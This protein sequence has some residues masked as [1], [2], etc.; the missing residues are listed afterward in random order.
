VSGDDWT[1]QER[2]IE[3][4]MRRVVHSFGPAYKEELSIPSIDARFASRDHWLVGAA[5]CLKAA[6]RVRDRIGLPFGVDLAILL[7]SSAE[8]G[9]GFATMSELDKELSDVAPML[10]LSAYPHPEP[11][12]GGIMP[13]TPAAPL[14]V[15]SPP[16]RQAIRERFDDSAGRYIRVLWAQG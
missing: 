9:W 15:T 4:W 13:G 10:T 5:E 8:K 12:E 1:A 6:I 2:L 14:I 11:H 7:T 16:T 3:T